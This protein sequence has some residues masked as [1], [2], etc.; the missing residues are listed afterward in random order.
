MEKVPKLNKGEKVPINW[1]QF[2]IDKMDKVTE[3]EIKKFNALRIKPEYKGIFEEEP[4]DMQIGLVALDKLTDNE[5]KALSAYQN[6][7]SKKKESRAFLV[8]FHDV[9]SK[10]AALREITGRKF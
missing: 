1:S 4:T 8:G 10:L 7:I 5:L 6:E 3:E 9:A 2:L